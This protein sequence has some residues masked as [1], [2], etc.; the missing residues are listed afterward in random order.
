[1][2]QASGAVPNARLR[3]GLDLGRK[4]PREDETSQSAQQT[5]S[6]NPSNQLNSESDP[7][8]TRPISSEPTPLDG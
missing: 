6:P 7:N 5:S 2:L 8:P 3:A 4:R 1:M